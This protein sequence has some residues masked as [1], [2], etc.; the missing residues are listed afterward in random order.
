MHYDLSL[1]EI[2]FS[3]TGSSVKDK[4]I[5]GGF[6]GFVAQVLNSFHLTVINSQN[7]FLSGKNS[8]ILQLDDVSFGKEK[9]KVNF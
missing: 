7:L 3:V 1:L 5:T 6:V 9:V 2:Y 4:E 8:F